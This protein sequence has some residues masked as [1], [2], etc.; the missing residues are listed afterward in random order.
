MLGKRSVQG[1]DKDQLGVAQED[2]IELW[3]RGMSIPSSNWIGTLFSVYR[4]GM[5]LGWGA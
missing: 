2:N 5:G 4:Q 1:S 3:G